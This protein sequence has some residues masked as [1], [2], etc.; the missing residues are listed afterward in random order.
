[1]VE[2]AN[3]YELWYSPDWCDWRWRIHG[4]KD[5]EIWQG[6]YLAHSMLTALLFVLGAWL[7]YKKVYQALWKQKLSL[8]NVVDGGLKPRPVEALIFGTTIHILG[9]F[10]HTTKILTGEYPTHALGEFSHEW[11][12][13]FLLWGGN[14]FVIGIIYSVPKTY[15]NNRG[16]VS[17]TF[18]I[19]KVRLPSPKA[20]NVIYTVL[21]L[22]PGILLPLFAILDGHMRDTGQFANAVIFNRL[23]YY[24][25][26]FCCSI[27]LP[28]LGY[29]GWKMVSI[30]NAN[31]EDVQDAGQNSHL[32]ASIRRVVINVMAICAL[33]G[34]FA[35]V[36][37][38]YATWRVQIHTTRW[39]SITFAFL[40]IFTSPL[41]LTPIYVVSAYNVIMSERTAT[42]PSAASLWPKAKPM[43]GVST[44]MDITTTAAR[45]LE[46]SSRPFIESKVP[47]TEGP[48]LGSFQND[49]E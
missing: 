35:V 45:P 16:S 19:S 48:T 34:S 26:L 32:K 10:I 8:L 4:C 1:M 20:I 12:W 25:W 30:L 37:G 43:K 31:L 14:L 6:F 22:V 36:V 47:G 41:L 27:P 39:L 21:A 38:S 23:H 5:S 7:C 40:W 44:T 28:I 11:P 49:Y 29:F 13:E 2:T 46:G 42:N 33:T 15:L 9:R 24:Q 17:N 18:T 3:D